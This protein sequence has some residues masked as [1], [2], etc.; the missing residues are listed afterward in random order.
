MKCRI[1]AC[2]ATL[3]ILLGPAREAI[4]ADVAGYAGVN[5]KVRS[6]PSA[7]FPAVGVFGAGSELTIHGCLSRYTWC[8][9]SASGVRGW[10]SGAHVQFVHEARRVYVPA[11]APRVEI[12]IVTF[13][14]TTYWEDYYRDRDFYGELDHWSH[15]HWDDDASPPGWRDN[16]DDYYD[17]NED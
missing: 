11:Y 5:L 10:A 16:W 4:A 6:G 3:L 9:V 14:L 12:P 8:D 13:N 7:R 15:S 17:T 1:V 2:A